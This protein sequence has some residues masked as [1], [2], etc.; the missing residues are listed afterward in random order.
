MGRR[1]GRKR[2]YM[3]YS[4]SP[5]TIDWLKNQDLPAS[6]IIDILVKKMRRKK[7]WL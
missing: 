6:R 1:K 2:V 7:N 3:T 5:D 4:L